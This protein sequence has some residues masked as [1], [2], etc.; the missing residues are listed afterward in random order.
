MKKPLTVLLFITILSCLLNAQ[1][2]NT[3][4]FMYTL[5]QSNQM[6]PAVQI[7]CKVYLGM[8]MLNSVE[9]SLGNSAFSY[10]NLISVKQDG[11]VVPNYNYFLSNKNSA[12]LIHT[13]LQINDF[14]LGIHVAPYYFTFDISEKVD[15]H[16]ILSNSLFQFLSQGNTPYVGTSAHLGGMTANATYYREYAL[17]AS[18]VFD[19][20][21]TL[22]VRGKLLFGK[23]DLN[24]TSSVIDWYTASDW[25]LIA[26]NTNMKANMSGPF[27]V[28]IGQGGRIDS[29]K[30]NFDVIPF[31]LNSQ[32]KGAA[33]DLGAIYHLNEQITLAASILDL[34]FI[35]W[36]SGV[37]NIS[38]TGN[39]S[40]N[41]IP[42]VK[43]IQSYYDSIHFAATTNPYNEFLS[44]KIFLGGTYQF[45]PSMNVGLM[46]RNE[47]FSNRLHSSITASCNTEFVKHLSGTLSYSWDY[48]SFT[49]VGLGIGY[50][51]PILSFY[52]IS[53]DVSGMIK[54]KS[55]R[56]ED[57]RFGFYWMFGCGGK[58]KKS[59]KNKGAEVS[60]PMGGT[61]ATSSSNVSKSIN[62]SDY[63][64]I[65]NT[66][67]GKGCQWISESNEKE[68]RREA[69][70]EKAKDKKQKKKKK[71][72][73]D[74]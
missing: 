30:N 20:K 33:I 7:P 37:T 18:R 9:F 65:S 64:H 43:S 61:Q 34:G 2:I 58:N 15:G 14:A 28:Y 17:G 46:G 29:I 8:P 40:F 60:A 48:N 57:I 16:I 45:I 44:A 12:D 59:E 22:G 36:A 41:G 10:S 4:Y 23:A 49:N 54:W 53:D 68:R 73:K 31:L 47:I 38:I 25:S 27:K 32:N 39:S 70:L 19:N 5:P 11:T 69:A 51:T 63:K 1:H 26:L 21:L 6:N 71:K 56:V 35:H 72:E 67:Y 42:D 55:A 52:M 50:R 3:L 13:E 62:P 74:E 24:I 66:T